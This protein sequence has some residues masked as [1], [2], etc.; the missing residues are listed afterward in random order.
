METNVTTISDNFS[1]RRVISLAG[2]YRGSINKSM[3]I[4]GI[5]TVGCF[6]T[7][8]LTMF[9]GRGFLMLYMLMSV[10][11]SL[12]ITLNPLVF[13]NRN[14]TLMAQVPQGGHDI[15]F[16]LLGRFHATC[17]PSPMDRAQSCR[18]AAVRHRPADQFLYRIIDGPDRHKLKGL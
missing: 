7:L 15:L 6:V 10:A 13:N 1:W 17:N 14:Q 8:L 3:I 2:F 11:M 4:C 18:W 16:P 5:A 12:S 9:A